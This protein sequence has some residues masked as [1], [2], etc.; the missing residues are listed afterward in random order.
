M[1][2]WQF[3]S[4]RWKDQSFEGYSFCMYIQS[5]WWVKS[6]NVHLRFF[7]IE[8]ANASSGYLSMIKGMLNIAIEMIAE[9]LGFK[10]LFLEMIFNTFWSSV[11]FNFD[12]NLITRY[13]CSV[14]QCQK[15][16][17]IEICCVL[18]ASRRT[19]ACTCAEWIGTLLDAV[20]SECR[21]SWV[22]TNEIANFP[23]FVFLLPNWWTNSS[24]CFL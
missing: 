5:R 16:P 22:N 14:W 8:I 6:F 3:A 13:S 19:N 23:R 11:F 7:F 4:T 20:I 2:G 15:L 9:H 1:T 17:N 10:S 12:R 24:C 18:V 21:S